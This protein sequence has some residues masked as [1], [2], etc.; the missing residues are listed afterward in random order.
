MA[1]DEVRLRLRAYLRDAARFAATLVRGEYTRSLEEEVVRLRAENRALA[2]SI[3]GVTGLCAVADG[4]SPRG[5]RRRS[6]PQ[7][8][9]ALALE[10][11]R[12]AQRERE[13]DIETFPPPRNVVRRN[14]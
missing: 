11:V 8:R 3:I 4:E 12:A 10:D 13:S 1:F 6:W 7:I 2:T 14:S 9:R 5:V